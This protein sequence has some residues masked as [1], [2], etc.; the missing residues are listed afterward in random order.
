MKRLLPTIAIILF[1]FT[2]YSQEILDTITQ[3]TCDC[4]SGKNLD[5]LDI[6]NLNVELG[7]CMIESLNRHENASKEL[8]INIYDAEGMT[9]FGEK[10]GARMAIKCPEVM[11]RIVAANNRQAT[12]Q[13]QLEGTIVRIEGNEFGFVV[14]RDAQAREHKLLWLRYFKNSEQLANNPR[15]M[16]G[17]KVRISFETIECYSPSERDYFERKE[18]RGLEF[19]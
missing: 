7:F 11:S 1:S 9:Q 5:N 13:N 8:N 16:I 18:I 14:L 2:C 3:E 12:S 19:L 6:E 10:V 15:Q 4:I 17:K